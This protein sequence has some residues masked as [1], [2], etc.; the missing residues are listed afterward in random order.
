[1]RLIY[2]LGLLPA[3]GA[4]LFSLFASAAEVNKKPKKKP[5]ESKYKFYQM[6]DSERGTYRFDSEGNPIYPDQKKKSAKTANKKK[7]PRAAAASIAAAQRQALAQ[8]QYKDREKLR[9]QVD[10]FLSA[11]DD[12][13]D[14]KEYEQ[15]I[16]YY[17]KVLA[18]SPGEQT[19]AGLR[20]QVKQRWAGELHQEGVSLHESGRL[21]EAAAKL[22]EALSL[23]PDNIEIKEYQAKVSQELQRQV[24]KKISDANAEGVRLYAGGRIK[25]AIAVWEKALEADPSNMK[26]KENIR[27]ARADLKARQ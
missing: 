18:L 13:S 19:A 26:L 24:D 11:A 7:N 22:D 20:D 3:L 16:S 5:E 10:A 12:H 6:L 8:K 21:S 4:G 15:A 14:R 1:M 23:E 27:T 9:E 2:R 17:D 25:E